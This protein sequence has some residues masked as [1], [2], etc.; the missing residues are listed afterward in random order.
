MTSKLHSSE[1]V[2]TDL[3][4]HSEA[5]IS[6]TQNT[7]H[8]KVMETWSTSLKVAGDV[9]GTGTEFVTRGAKGA[10]VALFKGARGIVRGL[11]A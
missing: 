5:R 1:W 3:L 2:T 7:T 6:S 4:T 10:T 9:V 8:Q 11:S